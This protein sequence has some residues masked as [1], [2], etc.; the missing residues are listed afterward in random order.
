VAIKSLNL[1]QY[2]GSTT[3]AKGVIVSFLGLKCYQYTG[4][5]VKMPLFTG[6]AAL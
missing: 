1:K 3:L 4:L 6:G 2:P 5:I